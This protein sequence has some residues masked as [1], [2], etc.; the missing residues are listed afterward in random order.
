MSGAAP[1]I[2]F[3]DFDGT[4]KPLDGPVSR[5]DCL[6][7]RAI[8][9]FGGIRAVATGRSI[10]TFER[11]WTPE[12]EIDY[13]ISSAG[14]ALSKWGADGQG[15]LLD[16]RMFEEED[17]SLVMKTAL[18]MD[19]GFSFCL[20][21]PRAHAFYYRLPESF[22]PPGSFL[23]VLGQSDREPIPWRGETGFPMGQCLLIAKPDLLR[24]KAELFKRAVPW[25]TSVFPTPPSGDGTLG[26][27][28]SPPGV[29]K[30]QAA[31]R[32]A[33]SLGFTRDDAVA[34][35]NDYN[36]TDLLEWAG[37]SRISSEGPRE[38]L[39]SFKAMPPAGEG[40][41][42]S[43]LQELCPGCYEAYLEKIKG[44]GA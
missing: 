38:M 33:K 6:A 43:V 31:E 12:I 13:L 1:K 7:L 16:V 30:G 9:S 39:E 21:P 11:D 32:L 10:R 14:L 19:I 37:T 5:E 41:I 40:P 34:L 20:P 8:G 22:D 15:E 28:I 24:Q 36:D 25:I 4:I 35:G 3:T 26:P 23:A 2:W 27:E 44:P 29:S 42:K 17:A 18:D